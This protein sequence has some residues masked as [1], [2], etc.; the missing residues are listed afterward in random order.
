MTRKRTALISLA[1]LTAGHAFPLAADGGHGAHLMEGL[2]Q[3]HHPVTTASPQ[4][5]KYFDQGLTLAYGF[6]H[7]E[8]A[9]SFRRAVE[10]D[11]ECAMCHWGI[12][13]VLGPNI[14]AAME[15][16]NHPEIRRAL[17]RALELAPRASA[18]E[19]AYIQALAERYGEHAAPDRSALDKAYAD[20]MRRVTLR[21]PEDLDAAVLFAEALMDTT[22][23]DYWTADGEPKP[24]TREFIDTLERVLKQ[25]PDHIGANH[26]LIHAV[27]K[28]RPDLGV[29]AAERLQGLPDGAP[30]H[31]IHMASH[32]YIRVG[33]YAD[34]ARVNE[35]AIAADEAYAEK[36]EVGTLYRVGY[37]P[38]NRHFLSAAASFEG[39]GQVALEATRTIAARVDRE[40]M[41]QPGFGTL[42]HY[43][44]TPIYTMVRFGRWDE[45]LA[46][47]QPA[48]DLV[49]PRGVWHFARGMALTRKGRLPEAAAE[50]EALRTLVADPRLD[51]VTL[52][53]INSARSLLRIGAEV[54]AGELA[55]ARGEYEKAIRRLQEG[56]RLEDALVYDEPPPWNLPVRQCLGAVLLEAGRPREAETVYRQDLDV[57]PW[58]GW[59]LYGLAQSLEAQGKTE[60][61]ADVRSRFAKA[62]E[63]ADVQLAAS[64][65]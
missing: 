4:A 6:N 59:S 38:H 34:A 40:L 45:I 33:R 51:G 23:W 50:L 36:A 53:D 60:E 26:F 8:A 15:P 10:L 64:R 57:Y 55:A 7:E 14:N 28:V 61:A 52:W 58:N 41:H 29:P 54:L 39:R 2:T 22:P 13:L 19:Q 21:Y 43:L 31:L 56:V 18:R 37:M 5:Q 65:L 47:P 46:E 16:E 25:D 1:I 32:I 42:Q 63:R 30:G 35:R 9:S 11:P 49:Y 24:V 44:M 48:A 62:W 17:D 3:H 27:E 20:A 12:A